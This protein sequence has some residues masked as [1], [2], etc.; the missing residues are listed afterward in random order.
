MYLNLGGAASLCNSVLINNT[1]ELGI[2]I[3]LLSQKSVIVLFFFELQLLKDTEWLK[4]ILSCVPVARMTNIC[5][6]DKI[7]T[8]NMAKAD[9]EKIRYYEEY[10]VASHEFPHTIIV[11]G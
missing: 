9:E 11:R 2:C 8:D 10:Y 6:L 5:P 7:L 3:F 4:D 1:V